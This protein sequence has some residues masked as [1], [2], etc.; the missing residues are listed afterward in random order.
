V[1]RGHVLTANVNA[2][3]VWGHVCI[4]CFFTICLHMHCTLCLLPEDAMYQEQCSKPKQYILQ[5]TTQHNAANTVLRKLILLPLAA[6]AVFLTAALAPVWGLPLCRTP[7][8]QHAALRQW[9]P[10]AATAP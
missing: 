5:L 2:G 8:E 4:N 3:E 7:T 1:C 10:L 6:A 9:S